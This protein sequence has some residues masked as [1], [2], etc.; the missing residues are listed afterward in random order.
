M[1]LTD[2]S[3]HKTESMLTLKFSQSGSRLAMNFLLRYCTCDG[4]SALE[5]REAAE[6]GTAVTEMRPEDGGGDKK[7]GKP[8][9]PV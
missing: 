4:P 1:R 2:I 5:R 9:I 8:S 7:F 3:F 6:Y